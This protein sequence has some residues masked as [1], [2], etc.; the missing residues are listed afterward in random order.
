MNIHPLTDMKLN[1]LLHGACPPAMKVKL[2]L[3]LLFLGTHALCI[4]VTSVACTSAA[5]IMIELCMCCL[6]SKQN[7]QETT[8]GLISLHSVQME[9][10]MNYLQELKRTGLFIFHM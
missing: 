3:L 1:L 2:N 6:A 7:N 8:A 9:L 10:K 4:K 5:L